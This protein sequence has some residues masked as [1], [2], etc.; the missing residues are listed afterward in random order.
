MHTVMLKSPV[1][2]T[3]NSADLSAM[4]AGKGCRLPLEVGR[5]YFLCG[6]IEAMFSLGLHCAIPYTIF[7]SGIV[8]L[9][10]PVK[11]KSSP[12]L[13]GIKSSRQIVKT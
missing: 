9:V 1:S 13:R 11:I 12:T 10:T 4:L 7:P 3:T 2:T 8:S 5:G 6:L